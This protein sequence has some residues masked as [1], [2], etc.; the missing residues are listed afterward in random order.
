M[1]AY[2]VCGLIVAPVSLGFAQ[3]SLVPEKNSGVSFHPLRTN[4]VS[5]DGV[6]FRRH[7]AFLGFSS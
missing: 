7:E 2:Y 6:T 4:A 3:R 1:P 5:G